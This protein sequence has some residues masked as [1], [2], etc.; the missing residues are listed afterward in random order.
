M[1]SFEAVFGPRGADGRPVQAYD[2]KTGRI[3]AEAV[4]HWRRYDIVDKLEREWPTIGPKLSGKIRVI[5]GGQDNFY[6]EG[7]TR[8][9]KQ[10]LKKL[11]S[12]ARVTVITGKDHGSVLFTSSVRAIVREM[13]DRF[14][15]SEKAPPKP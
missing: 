6:L 13:A 7:A 3:N 2:R 11:G 14:D 10:A 5:I 8:L 9:L 1:Q 15:E 4:K 12:D